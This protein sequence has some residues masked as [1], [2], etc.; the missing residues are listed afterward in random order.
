MR[1]RNITVAL[2]PTRDMNASQTQTA[3]A[4]VRRWVWIGYWMGMFA[5]THVPAPMHTPPVPAGSD[6]A[7]HFA[8]FGGLAWLGIR[9]RLAVDLKPR[10]AVWIA[11]AGVYMI[12]AGLDEW[13]QRFVDRMPSLY[14][15]L[16]DVAGVATATLLL[17]LLHRSRPGGK[18]A[19]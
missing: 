3:N 6:T 2:H 16:A 5:L 10:T 18:P 8:L 14:D 13:L 9:W 17:I 12:Y 7:V 11:W 19:V 4:V 1:F 15:W